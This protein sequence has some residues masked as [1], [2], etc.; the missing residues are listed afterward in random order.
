MPTLYLI[1]QGAKLKK[2]SERLVV[3]KNGK[4]LLEVPASKV[5]RILIYGNITIT[6][7]VMVFLLENAIDTSFL[8]IYGRYRGRLLPKASKNIYLRIAQFEKNK[9]EKFKLS[10]AGQILKGKIKNS[11]IVLS[12][13]ASNHPEV[14]F[15][16]HISELDK[17][18]HSLER[19]EKLSTLLGVEG[20]ASAVY[21]SAFP[22]M[23]RG[24]F[25]FTVRSRRPPRDPINSLL[26]FGYTLLTNEINSILYALG[27]DP[28]VGYLHGI[29]YGRPSLALDSV[30][31]FR[32]LAERFTLNLINNGMIKESDFEKKEKGFYLR[33]AARK[34][35]FHHYEK[36]MLK[37]F[38]YWKLKRKVTYRELFK[39]QAQNLARV[40]QKGG[41]YEPF[42][43]IG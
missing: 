36:R 24:D 27:F 14:D 42:Q 5:D 39:I 9:D 37:S 38:D 25:E 26:S 21:F 13:Y 20:R 6:T 1:D 7:P 4:V 18:F 43:A 16:Y 41:V 30:E 8:S 12:K 17:Q 34:V 19:K 33:E 35:F 31:E 11:R 3:E 40:I 29:N 2:T 32:H 28:Y 23:I 10:L 22:K 15:S